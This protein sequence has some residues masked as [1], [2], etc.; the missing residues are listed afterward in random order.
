MDIIIHSEGIG[1]PLRQLIQVFETH[2]MS[3]TGH[4]FHI[5]RYIYPTLCI[6]EQAIGNRFVCVGRFNKR[7]MLHRVCAGGIRHF[8]LH[9]LLHAITRDAHASWTEVMQE[10]GQ[11]FFG[12]LYETDG[13]SYKRL[14]LT[15][16][17]F[18]RD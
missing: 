2:T 10:L 3:I 16:F 17:T 1:I 6:L 8:E 7:C 18:Y 4:V 12:R 13:V 11:R 9:I 15:L 5:I 14:L